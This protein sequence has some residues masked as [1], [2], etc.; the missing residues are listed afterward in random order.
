[1]KAEKI[2]I[3]TVHI[4]KKLDLM[5]DICEYWKKNREI[6]RDTHAIRL[7]LMTLANKLAMLNAMEQ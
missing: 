3:I 6:G 5:A 2:E 4:P 1:M 7:A